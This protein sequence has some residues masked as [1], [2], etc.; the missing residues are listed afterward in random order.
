MA[1]LGAISNRATTH[2]DYDRSSNLDDHNMPTYEELSNAFN[3]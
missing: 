2:F 1:C 3:E